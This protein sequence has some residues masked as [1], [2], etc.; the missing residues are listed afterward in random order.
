MPRRLVIILAVAT[1]VSVANNYYAQPLLATIRRP[2]TQ[3]PVRPA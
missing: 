3:A 2:S 1:G